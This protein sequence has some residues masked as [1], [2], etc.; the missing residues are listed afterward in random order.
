MALKITLK[1]FERIAIGSMTLTNGC[2]KDS[3][4]TISGSAPVLRQANMMR[5]EC[6]DSCLKKAY[7]CL[8][9]LYLEQGDATVDM[10]RLIAARVLRQMPHVKAEI[11]QAD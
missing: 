6:A 5:A 3:T 4:F 11:Q 8:Q 9:N 10:Y 7:L 2:E 1:P